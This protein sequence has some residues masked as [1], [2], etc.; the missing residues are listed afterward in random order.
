MCDVDSLNILLAISILIYNILGNL[1]I[2]SPLPQFQNT[3]P[4]FQR[5]DHCLQRFH[6]RHLGDRPNELILKFYVLSLSLSLS[7]FTLTWRHA[8]VL[9][10]TKIK[11]EPK[12]LSFPCL[13]TFCVIIFFLCSL[14][15]LKEN[16]SPIHTL[17]THFF[18]SPLLL[19]KCNL[20]SAPISLL[21]LLLIKKLKK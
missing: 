11:Q 8:Q 20:T 14:I 19:P 21:I 5:R 13:Q 17:S 3:Y 6:I 4:C 12:I 2:I 1:H 9:P 18:F 15:L 10:H 7:F 16:H